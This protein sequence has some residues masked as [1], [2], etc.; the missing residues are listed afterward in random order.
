MFDITSIVYRRIAISPE[1]PIIFKCKLNKPMHSGVRDMHLG[2]LPC[3]AGINAEADAMHIQVFASEP[4]G[5]IVLLF[6]LSEE[7]Y[8]DDSMSALGKR[9]LQHCCWCDAAAVVVSLVR[10][11]N[12]ERANFPKRARHGCDVANL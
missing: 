8:S 12:S 11:S 9:L 10:F 5:S 4:S 6:L 7:E 2:S 1:S 3:S